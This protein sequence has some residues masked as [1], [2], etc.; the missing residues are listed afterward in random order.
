MVFLSML[1]AAPAGGA[2]GPDPQVIHRAALAADAD[3]LA[4]LAERHGLDPASREAFADLVE[5]GAVLTRLQHEAGEHVSFD[6]PGYWECDAGEARL[7][8]HE[9]ERFPAD[10][11]VDRLAGRAALLCSSVLDEQRDEFELGAE[12]TRA[13]HIIGRLDGYLAG[14]VVD[15]YANKDEGRVLRALQ[16]WLRVARLCIES[17]A[18]SLQV[19]GLGSHTKSLALTMSLLQSN[20]LT[21]DQKRALVSWWSTRPAVDLRGAWEAG[22]HDRTLESRAT[23]SMTAHYSRAAHEAGERGFFSTP[24]ELFVQIP[25]TESVL[26]ACDRLV[27]GF[28]DGVR[29]LLG[30]GMQGLPQSL[31]RLSR[32]TRFDVVFWAGL[33]PE[34]L[35]QAQWG[36]CVDMA[37]RGFAKELDFNTIQWWSEAIRAETVRRSLPLVLQIEEFRDREGRY[38][39]DLSRLPLASVPL[40]PFGADGAELRYL[41][42]DPEPRW[43]RRYDLYSVGFDG[44][45][46]DPGQLQ[47]NGWFYLHDPEEDFRVN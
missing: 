3:R 15:A 6:T 38:P 42:R 2:E 21:I 41:V 16:R 20:D 4:S 23:V 32:P 44:D 11:L 33:P 25:D 24:S 17:G 18:S 13:S 8:R 43:G 19:A 39:E 30:R 29:D 45:A 37:F 9:P 26:L 12:A 40:D 28:D 34:G 27:D 10:A 35:T 36:A 1:C 47:D 5:L 31:Y 7:A 22:L 14:A 46:R